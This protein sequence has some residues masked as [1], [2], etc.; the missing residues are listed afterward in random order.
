M[1]PTGCGAQQLFCKLVLVNIF[2]SF[3][4]FFVLKILDT[5]FYFLRRQ[6]TKKVENNS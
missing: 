4:L 2:Q 1:H 5:N 6:E 3:L